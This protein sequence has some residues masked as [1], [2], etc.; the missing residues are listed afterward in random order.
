MVQ[1][2]PALS[3]SKAHLCPPPLHFIVI[4]DVN[5]EEAW[6]CPRQHHH[7]NFSLPAV[8]PLLPALGLFSLISVFLQ[9]SWVVFYK[10]RLW[11]LALLVSAPTA[12]SNA[13]TARAP[14]NEL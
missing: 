1:S 6:Q 10:L 14:E 11:S 2:K 12:R 5:S 3:D 7:A 4:G 8:T 9:P 13:P